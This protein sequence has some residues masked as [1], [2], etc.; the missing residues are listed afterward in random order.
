MANHYPHRLISL[1]LAAAMMSNMVVTTGAT[2]TSFPDM[3]ADYSTTALEAAVKNGLLSGSDGFLL[4]DENLTRAQM[5]KILSV[6][7]GAVNQADMTAFDDVDS[8]AWYYSDMAKAVEMKLFQGDGSNLNPDSAISRQEVFVVLARA[9]AMT[10]DDISVVNIFGDADAIAP[11]ALDSTAALIQAGM[12]AGDDMGNINP[13]D[14]I[15]RKDFAVMMDRLVATYISQTGKVTQVSQGTVLVNTADVTLDGITITGDLIIGDG[16]GDG[17]ITL[18]NVTVEGNVIVRG[19]GEN[20]I[21]LQGKTALSNV[22][23]AKVEGGVRLYVKSSTASVENVLVNDGRNDITVEGNV[24]ALTINAQTNV[25]IKDGLVS[26]VSMNA[27]GVA[28]TLADDAVVTSLVA[29]A[30]APVIS[31]EK[32]A[33]VTSMTIDSSAT[34]ATVQVEKGGSVNYV[35]LQADG[36]TISGSG[37]VKSATVE[38]NQISV[39]TAGTKTEVAD[40]VVGTTVG[41]NQVAGGE[42]ATEGTL[43]SVSTTTTTYYTVT[44]DHN[45][46]GDTDTAVRVKRGSSASIP[47]DVQREGFTFLGWY[48]DVDTTYSA[49][50]VYGN[51]T[52]YAK[53]SKEVSNMNQFDVVLAEMVTSPV[54]GVIVAANGETDDG[55][56]YIMESK[57]V[58]GQNK[59]TVDLQ[60]KFSFKAGD[61][62]IDLTFQNMIVNNPHQTGAFVN[63]AY[64]STPYT[65]VNMTVSHVTVNNYFSSVISNANGDVTVEDSV[66]NTM[67]QDGISDNYVVKLYDNG[68]NFSV[69]NSTFGDC[70]IEVIYVQKFADSYWESHPLTVETLNRTASWTTPTV[71]GA[72]IIMTENLTWNSGKTVTIPEGIT[73][74]VP[75]NITLVV[76]NGAAL[77]NH[78]TLDVQG[79]IIVTYATVASAKDAGALS[80]YGTMLYGS[81]VST[82]TSFTTNFTSAKDQFFFDPVLFNAAKTSAS[83][84]LQI[85]NGEARIT[86]NGP[87]IEKAIDIEK[88]YIYR[89]EL[90]DFANLGTE[91]DDTALA[92]TTCVP[93]SAQPI[94]YFHSSGDTTA[95]TFDGSSIG[96]LVPTSLMGDHF[97][98][99][100][101]ARCTDGRY[102]VTTVVTNEAGESVSHTLDS[103]SVFRDGF[104]W[105]IYY[106]T[107]ANS[108]GYATMRNFSFNE[109]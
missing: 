13:T 93:Y 2:D 109:V 98:I 17:D 55:Q 24:G 75:E 102:E 95:I 84:T 71:L 32:G 106:P 108:D 77:V 49:G 60:G 40:H 64:A 7:F 72:D 56:L 22:I 6:A 39:D 57:V 91:A 100:S 37:T 62:D 68:S 61:S 44:F 87:Y 70:Q 65:N 97:T 23:M 21:V 59:V 69:V 78:G 20:S 83:D 50:G 86:G 45:Y 29:S 25:I 36:A 14:N 28:L 33:S 9:F 99:T 104:A 81:T 94:V 101:T 79:D 1:T 12:V 47:T 26:A 8:E 43:P 27:E 76:G 96:N 53:W 5:G 46:E 63:D 31:V 52:V 54:G 16:V 66:F 80:N 92:I 67:E 4:P 41:G 73:L 85:E 10:S 107:G 3:P 88:E 15:S 58:D 19:G 34:D 105:M 90:S 42:T 30:Q 18:N 82:P 11:W 35:A 89:F 48:T 74:T 51:T 38:G 103:T